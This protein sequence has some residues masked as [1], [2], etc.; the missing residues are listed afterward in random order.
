M[1]KE[2]AYLCTNSGT[3][4][5]VSIDYKTSIA[6]ITHELNNKEFV[7][8]GDVVWRS[9]DIKYISIKRDRRRGQGVC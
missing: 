6:I 2:I 9:S 7:R 8:V 5:A 3:I 4:I 1:A